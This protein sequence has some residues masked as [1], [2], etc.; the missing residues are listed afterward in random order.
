[1]RNYIFRKIKTKKRNNYGLI[2][3]QIN[4]GNQSKNV[5]KN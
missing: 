2:L 1:M 5:S 4:M 3:I